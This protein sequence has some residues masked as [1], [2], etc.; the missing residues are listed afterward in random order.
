MYFSKKMLLFCQQ[1]SIFAPKNFL[2]YFCRMN[3]TLFSFSLHT[4]ISKLL[5][6]V[7]MSSGKVELPCHVVVYR[8]PRFFV[9]V[10]IFAY[11]SKIAAQ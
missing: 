2:I 11:M 6:F 1:P 9:I 7:A 4:Q 10:H 8:K 3:E 5:A